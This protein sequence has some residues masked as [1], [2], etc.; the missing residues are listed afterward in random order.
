MYERSDVQGG[1]EFSE[2]TRQIESEVIEWIQKVPI[3]MSY[4]NTLR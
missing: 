1:L 3:K 4:S 2:W